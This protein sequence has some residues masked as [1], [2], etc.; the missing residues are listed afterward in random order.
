[1][2][3][4][5]I[6]GPAVAAT[7]VALALSGVS[8]ASAKDK[9]HRA[10]KPAAEKMSCNA[11]NGCPGMDKAKDDRAPPADAKPPEPK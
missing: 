5:I 9:P 4:K 8:P 1:M 10:D 2:K 3:S 7:A 6:S 11:K